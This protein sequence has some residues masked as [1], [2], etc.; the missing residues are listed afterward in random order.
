MLL[1]IVV[2]IIE[3]HFILFDIVA[4]LVIALL[5]TT[6]YKITDRALI[7]K[8]HDIY[9]ILLFIILNVPEI[10]LI[11]FYFNVLILF[12]IIIG[13]R[14]AIVLIVDNIWIEL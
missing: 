10:D 12:P 1:E 8:L 7:A 13:F 3:S 9:I 11:A 4:E 5:N 2:I 14:S 6:N